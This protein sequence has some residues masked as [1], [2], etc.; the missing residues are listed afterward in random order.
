VG[1]LALMIAIAEK[2]PAET[3]EQL[4]HRYA[5]MGT[6]NLRIDYLRPGLG[7]FFVASAEVTRLGGR[8]G[9][10]LMRLV[11]DQGTL[12]ATGAGNY[13]VS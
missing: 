3:T 9:L 13:I 4:Q 1:G 6:I 2:H 11:N 5:R 8:I 12:I 10:T 7:T